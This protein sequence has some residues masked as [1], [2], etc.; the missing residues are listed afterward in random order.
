LLTK[1]AVY[2]NFNQRI[3]LIEQQIAFDSPFLL[4]K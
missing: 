2:F 1:Q 4:Q 3:R